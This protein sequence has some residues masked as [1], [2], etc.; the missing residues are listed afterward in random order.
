EYE[1]GSDG[2]DGYNYGSDQGGEDAP[3]DDARVA[4]ENAYYEGDDFRQDQP[5]KA[6]ELFEKVVQLETELGDEVKWRFKALGQMVAL[7]FRLRNHEAMLRR[8]REMLAFVGSVTRNECTDAVN[9]ILDTLA[10]STDLPI[11]GQMYEMTLGALKDSSNERM[12]FN[13]N[14]K[15]A[16]VYMQ[17]GDA[18]AAD[19]VINELHRS[20]Q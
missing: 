1:Y 7:H 2:D 13:T 19:K 3:E 14:V 15:L 12:W 5:K 8:Y 10:T 6:L 20:C 9:G 18:A 4:I 16:R 17:I 11:V